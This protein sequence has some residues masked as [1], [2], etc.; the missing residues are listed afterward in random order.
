M[1]NLYRKWTLFLDRDGVIN[2][3]IEGDYV[4]NWSQFVF[5]HGA[6][7]ALKKLSK[8]FH[9][10]IIVTN[11]RGIC[12]KLMTEDQLML[13][14]EKMVNEIIFS[15][16]R[17]DKIYFC[18]ENNEFA[19]CRK[20]NPGM[21]LK[22]K[23][24]FPEIDFEKSIM[25]GDSLSD[26][27]FAKKLGMKSVYILNKLNLNIVMKVDPDYRFYSLLDFSQRFKLFNFDK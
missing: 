2:E 22:A 15:G 24:D 13:I 1:I 7:I 4:K 17:I 14:H 3:K 16:G 5:C 21:G 27:E 25:V 12:K 26:I 19:S 20:P 6:L 8:V 10:I 11:Q 23:I 18:K 9:R